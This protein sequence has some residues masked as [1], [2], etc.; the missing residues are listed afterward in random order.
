MKRKQAV[1]AGFILLESLIWG[2]GNPVIK[3]T[4]SMIPTFTGITLRFFLALLLFLLFFGRRIWKNRKI[5]CMPSLVVCF[6]TA[7]SFTLGNFALRLTEA[8]TAGFLMGIAVIFTP[9]LERIFLKKPIPWKILPLVLV[10]CAGMYLLCCGNGHFVFGFGEMLAVLCSFSFAMMLTFSEK[11]IDDLDIDPI[12]LS[13]MQCAFSGAFALVLALIFD[14]VYDFS[15]M[16]IFGVFSVA[17]L[18]VCSTFMACI[19][20]NK[21]MRYIPATL[22]SLAFS[23][24][25]VFTAL[26]SYFMLGETLSGLGFLGGAIV[27]AGV[28]GAS[29]QRK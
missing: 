7:T 13:A 9:F 19:L 1:Y 10:V 15:R 5:F 6:F 14:G 29:I 8:T 28:M 17:Y 20:Q 11:Y 26:F 21:A 23:T 2:L 22:A 3:S 18:G 16:N 25:P 27:I 24:E 12:A 4:A